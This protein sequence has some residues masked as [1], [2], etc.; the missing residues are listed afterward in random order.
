MPQ[1]YEESS[2]N[3]RK[4]S[5]LKSLPKPQRAAF[6]F[7]SALSLGVLVLWL[8]Q[9]NS[10]LSGPFRTPA[11]EKITVTDGTV[12]LQTALANFDTDG[13]GLTDQ[14]EI[15]LYSTSPYL[16]DSDSDG[17]NDRLEIE[18]GSDPNCATGQNCVGQSIPAVAETVNPVSTSS[19]VMPEEID[20]VDS[21]SENDLQMMMGGQA[22]AAQL[23]ALLLDSGADASMLQKLSDEDLLKSYQ[24]MLAAQAQ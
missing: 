24:E 12:D 11:G 17:L 22:D 13:D 18:N 1:K 2:K 20:G 19:A 23:R 3:E 4:I 6:L 21:A 5:F 8:W 9:F 7:L 16:E 15:N 10:R 14:E